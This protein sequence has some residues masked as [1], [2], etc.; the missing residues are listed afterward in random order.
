MILKNLVELPINST[1]DLK[2]L[3]S[4]GDECNLVYNKKKLYTNK[5]IIIFS[6]F[7]IKNVYLLLKIC[8][9]FVK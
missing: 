3:C 4:T 1:F 2:F 6:M 5:P 9:V 8:K 7:V